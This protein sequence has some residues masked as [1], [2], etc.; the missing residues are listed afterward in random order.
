MTVSYLLEATI[1]CCTQKAKRKQVKSLV[2]TITRR[3]TDISAD[4]HM[5]LD[6]PPSLEDSELKWRMYQNKA[7]SKLVKLRQGNHLR[8][9]VKWRKAM[10][11]YKHNREE[12]RKNAQELKKC[13]DFALK[14]SGYTPKAAVLFQQ[15]DMG[16]EI[17]EG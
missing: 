14:R 8:A 16:M 4:V 1:K 10:K 2:Q 6:E 15:T 13:F 17:I 7:R 3:S 11:K 5:E 9:R 12:Q